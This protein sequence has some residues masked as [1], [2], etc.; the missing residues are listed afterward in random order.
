MGFGSSVCS[1]VSV[2]SLSLP[3]SLPYPALII[4]IK[5]TEVADLSSYMNV[6]SIS[7]MI[8]PTFHLFISPISFFLLSSAVASVYIS[9][10]SDFYMFELQ[11]LKGC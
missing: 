4:V 8:S 10:H 3:P 1:S 6:M 5:V 7:F 11:T 9:L 2:Y